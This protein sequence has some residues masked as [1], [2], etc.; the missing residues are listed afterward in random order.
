LITFII[1]S[2]NNVGH[3]TRNSKM[4]HRLLKNGRAKVI[5]GGLKQGDPIVVKLLDKVFNESEIKDVE[6]RIGI[7]PGYR[8]IGYCVYKI[9]NNKVVKLFAGEV[10]TRTSEVIKNLSDR[11]MYRNIRRQHR[12]KNVKRKFDS[13]KFRHPIWKNRAKHKFQPTHWHLINSHKN[14]LNW[15]FKRI[16]KEQCKL[17]IEYNKFDSQKMINPNIRNWQYSKGLQYGFENIKSYIRSRDNYTCQICNKN[18]GNIRNEVHH[19]IPKSKGGSNRPDNLILLCPD[20]HKKVHTGKATCSSKLI[21]KKDFRDAGVLNSC[22]KHMFAEF[23]DILSTQDTYGYITNVVRHNWK[24]E[25]THSNDASIIALCDSNGLVDELKYYDQW[26]DEKIIINFKQHRRHVRNYVKRYEDR[27]YY[28]I[29]SKHPKKAVAWNRNR[30]TGQDKKKRSLTELKRYLSDKKI[31]NKIQIMVKPGRKVYRRNNKDIVFRPGDTIKCSKGVD[32]VRGWASTQRK[33][34]AE[35]LGA[36]NQKDCVVI[37]H[38]CGLV[39]S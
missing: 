19:I 7:D 10:E 22:M 36:I 6:Y 24:L 30:R 3:P 13:V 8:H 21:K 5:G 35:K 4:V 28:I 15:I 26:L 32:V 39:M 33:V 2:E 14:L 29:N 27:K 16:P 34:I 17:H 1:D 38:N 37:K 11:K 20:C 12:R 18:V 9:H 31:L 23:E 25:K